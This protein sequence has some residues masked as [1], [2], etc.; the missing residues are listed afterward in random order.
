MYSIN[1]DF[2][3]IF[4][5]ISY[6]TRTDIIKEIYNDDNLTLSKLARKFNMAKQTLEFH[7][8]E[9]KTAGIIT[10]R[11]KKGTVRLIFNRKGIDK[12]I[13]KFKSTISSK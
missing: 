4:K 6:K 1:T 5:V 10:S 9:L 8:K 11:R 3:K 13:D 7:I 2:N 12:A